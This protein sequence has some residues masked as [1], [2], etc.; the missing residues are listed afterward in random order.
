MVINSVNYTGIPSTIPQTTTDPLLIEKQKKLDADF[1]KA[2]DEYEKISPLL[3]FMPVHE[4][5]FIIE[6]LGKGTYKITL[7]GSDKIT[8]KTEAR[9]WWLSHKVNPDNI[10]IDYLPNL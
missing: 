7:L 1:S 8:A 2:M 5:H 10:K 9:N 4:N 3:R 6:Y